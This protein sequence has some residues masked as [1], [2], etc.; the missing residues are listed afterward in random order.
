MLRSE[1]D[2][3]EDAYLVICQR[4]G[5]SET[6]M[7]AMQKALDDN[8]LAEIAKVA[9]AEIADIYARNSS[10]IRGRN[11]AIFTV[12]HREVSKAARGHPSWNTAAIARETY[13]D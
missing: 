13:G 11:V 2:Q 10:G 9:T 7:K 4:L 5:A 1:L 8:G 6:A 12:I 3:L